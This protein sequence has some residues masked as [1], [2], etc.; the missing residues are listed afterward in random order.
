MA[1]VLSTYEIFRAEGPPP[2]TFGNVFSAKPMFLDEQ[3]SLT[4]PNNS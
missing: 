2:L 3:S 4:I 1:G